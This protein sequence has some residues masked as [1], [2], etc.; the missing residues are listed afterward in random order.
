MFIMNENLYRIHHDNL[1]IN[2][3]DK[4]LIWHKLSYRG[5]DEKVW[6]NELVLILQEAYILPPGEKGPDTLGPSP[7]PRLPPCPTDSFRR[8]LG[9]QMSLT[10]V[11]LMPIVIIGLFLVIAY[12]YR[13]PLAT[14]YRERLVPVYRERIVPVYRERIVPVYRERIVQLYPK[15]LGAR[16]K[17]PVEDGQAGK[18]ASKE[19][20]KGASKEK[21]KGA[22]KEKV[23]RAS[24]EQLKSTRSPSKEKAKPGSPTSLK[25]NKTVNQLNT[26][27][28]TKN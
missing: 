27:K 22:S 13:Q 20:V 6:T 10:F 24:K 26:A 15:K 11:W 18:S 28:S 5:I 4:K 23:K 8:S 12:I 19:K 17:Q 9:D 25:S 21:V 7:K 16:S 1:F 2:K 3:G 14:F